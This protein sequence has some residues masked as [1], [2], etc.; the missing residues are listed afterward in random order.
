MALRLRPALGASDRDDRTR[1]VEEVIGVPNERAERGSRGSDACLRETRS[2]HA[3]L[4]D[5]SGFPRAPRIATE[6]QTLDQAQRQPCGA[7]RPRQQHHWRERGGE[8]AQRGPRALARQNRAGPQAQ[9]GDPLGAHSWRSRPSPLCKRPDAWR[10]LVSSRGSKRAAVA[11]RGPGRSSCKATLPTHRQDSGRRGRALVSA[12]ST[13]RLRWPRTPDLAP[14]RTLDLAPLPS[15]GGW[16]F[17]AHASVEGRPRKGCDREWSCSSRFAG[18]G[19]SRGC[20]RTRWLG[21]TGCIAVAERDLCGPSAFSVS[22]AAAA[23]VTIAGTDVPRFGRIR[24]NR[25]GRRHHVDA[26]Y[27]LTE[28]ERDQRLSGGEC[29]STRARGSWATALTPTSH[30]GQLTSVDRS[31]LMLPHARESAWRG[32]YRRMQLPCPSSTIVRPH[33]RLAML[34]ALRSP[35]AIIRRAEAGGRLGLLSV[36]TADV[37]AI[38]PT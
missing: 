32:A 12:T 15:D 31:R 37:D 24:A 3:A 35:A 38:T 14:V 5:R 1:W 20:R 21:S 18:T 22:S 11:P 36:P 34:P 27:V 2:L 13:L 19:S 16:T 7:R 33:G 26:R 9:L 29:L 4:H 28:R 23:I 30:S 10:S 8:C 6:P 17:V 25:S